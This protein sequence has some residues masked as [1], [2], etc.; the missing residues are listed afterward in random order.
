MSLTECTRP[1]VTLEEGF[2]SSQE[3]DRRIADAKRSLGDQ[4][5]I[6]GHHYQRDDVIQ[7][8]DYRGDS[9]QLSCIAAGLKHARYIVFCGVHFM[10]ETAD[11][12]T[13]DH[14]TV[15]L[16]DRNAGC[17]MADMADIQDVEECWDFLTSQYGDT[18][19]PVTYV[20]SSADVKAFVGRHGGLTCT[21]SNAERVFAHAF[22]L[23]PRILFLPDQHLGRNTGAK[24]GISLHQMAVYD[25]GEMNLEFPDGGDDP[26]LIL[27]KGH[28]SVHQR[29]EPRHVREVREKYPGIRVIV[30][31]ECR[32]ET[33]Q[34]ADESGS[35]DYIIRAV[36]NAPP[37]TKWAIGTEHNLVHRLAKEHPEQWIIS[38]NEMVCPCLTMNRIDRP[39]LLEALEHLAAGRPTGVIRVPDDTARWARLAID[40]MLSLS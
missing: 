17:S 35:T 2:L 21:S 23:K 37:G 34:L 6:L 26:R 9:L 4:L 31:P 19:L 14:Q 7:F 24:L 3:L 36:K 28:C 10:A 22:Q 40:R 33:V 8:A 20:N 39:H 18:I 1:S 12:L 5:V 25:P 16:P 30:H 29:F 32:Y 15:I 13:G 27:W 38:L 11:I